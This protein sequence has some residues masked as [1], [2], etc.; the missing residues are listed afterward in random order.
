MKWFQVN[1]VNKWHNNR[2]CA[3]NHISCMVDNLL[4]VGISY[5]RITS[6][7]GKVGLTWL[8]TTDF[9]NLTTVID[10]ELYVAFYP[11]SKFWILYVQRFNDFW[12]LQKR[13]IIL[14]LIDVWCGIY[15]SVGKDVKTPCIKLGSSRKMNKVNYY[16]HV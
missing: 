3:D 10:S 4:N 2:W 13:F 8:I 14:L 5:V 9:C 6:N 12:L 11:R 1:N 15:D 7:S 16:I